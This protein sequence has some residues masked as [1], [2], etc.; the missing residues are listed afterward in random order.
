VVFANLGTRLGGMSGQVQVQA[1]GGKAY[2]KGI[3]GWGGNPDLAVGVQC[4]SAAGRWWTPWPFADGLMVGYGTVQVTAITGDLFDNSRCTAFHG[5]AYARVKCYAANGV[6]VD[7]PF[8][9]I[10][11]S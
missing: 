9:V 8:T 2:C 11:G 4:Y 7:V 3:D 5:Y 1:V 10:I 6:P